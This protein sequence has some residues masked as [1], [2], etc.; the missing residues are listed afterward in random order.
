MPTK[1]HK[2]LNY[3]MPILVSLRAPTLWSG[4]GLPATRPLR[5]AKQGG[6]DAAML[7]WQNLGGLEELHHYS[8]A[9]IERRRAGNPAVF[10]TRELSSPD[11]LPAGR[12]AHNDRYLKKICRKSGKYGKIKP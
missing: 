3:E 1:P 12:Q 2:D 7:I 8:I 5:L 4:R 10:S 6:R 9:G 11:S